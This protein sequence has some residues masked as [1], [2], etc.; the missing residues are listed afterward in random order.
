M[1]TAKI[2]RFYQHDDSDDEVTATG[3]TWNRRTATT[4]DNIDH[5]QGRRCSHPPSGNLIRRMN[6]GMIIRKKPAPLIAA[7]AAKPQPA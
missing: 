1:I 3:L 5:H 6:R 7:H 4:A 2:V